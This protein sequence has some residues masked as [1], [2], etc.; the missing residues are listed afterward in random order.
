MNLP[1]DLDWDADGLT[2]LQQMMQDCVSP[3]RVANFQDAICASPKTNAQFTA[4]FQEWTD[5]QLLALMAYCAL[6]LMSRAEPCGTSDSLCLHDVY[7]LNKRLGT[8]LGQNIMREA[9]GIP[10]ID[11]ANGEGF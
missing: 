8:W 5:S 7:R 11:Y 2:L 9:I 4:T 6:H 3:S 1:G 10:R